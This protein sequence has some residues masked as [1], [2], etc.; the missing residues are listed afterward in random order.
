MT[1]E[2]MNIHKALCELKLLDARI[3]KA[4][5]ACSFVDT[6]KV[7]VD[8]IRGKTS[9]QFKQTERDLLQ[10]AEDLMARRTAIKRAVVLSNATTKVQVGGVEYTVAEAIEMKNHGMDGKRMLMTRMAQR[11]S[12]VEMAVDTHN[13]GAE[14]EAD[15]YTASCLNGKEANAAEIAATRDHRL[16]SAQIELVDAVPN[17]IRNY[18]AKLEKEIGDFTTEVDAAL[19]TSNAT[20]M[21]TIEY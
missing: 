2:T 20:T 10:S 15:R 4:I 11:M 17:G 1:V 13:A 14:A 12:S 3:I 8:N 19:S 7:I 6:K 16:K 5:N 9:E 18:I 21:I